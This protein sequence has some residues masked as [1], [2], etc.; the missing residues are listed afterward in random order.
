MVAVKVITPITRSG[1]ALVQLSKSIRYT[2][3]PS[4]ELFWPLSSE[5]LFHI[6]C[7]NKC[8]PSLRISVEPLLL[9]AA[10][11]VVSQVKFS[12]SSEAFFQSKGPTVTALTN[13]C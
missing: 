4:K 12:G 11:V 13:N 5:S 7:S 3:D 6:A 1:P 8:T 9:Q 2:C 10:G